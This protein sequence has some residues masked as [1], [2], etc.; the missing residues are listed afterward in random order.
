[1]QQV[2]FGLLE[3]LLSILLAFVLVFGAYRLYLAL[4]PRLD[5]ERQLRSGNKALGFFLGSILLG[6]AIVVKQAVYP[7]MAVIQLFAASQERS[8]PG[9]FKMLGLS[10][11][12]ILLSGLLALF[13]MLF[14]LWLFNRA[15]PGIDL[16]EEI[17]G[18]NLAVA[19]LTGLLILG[20]SLLVSQGVAGLTR[21]LI[22]FP[23]V[24]TVPLG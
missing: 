21:A 13:C 19:L 1:M 9:F 16:F 22:P 11:G 6:E 24:G 2:L 10:L 15:T 20:I 12:Y 8:L 5:E 4:T 18:D 14:C 7:V 3:F 17:G 23:A